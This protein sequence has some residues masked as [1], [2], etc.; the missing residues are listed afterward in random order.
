MSARVYASMQESPPLVIEIKSPQ[1][2]R[3]SPRVKY[4]GPNPHDN[5]EQEYA[6]KRPDPFYKVEIALPEDEKSYCH[7]RY[8]N[9]NEAFCQESACNSDP[10]DLISMDEPLLI[11]KHAC[12]EGYRNEKA[13]GII[14]EHL[15]RYI[16][17]PDG[18][19]ENKGCQA[20][21]LL[22]IQS[23]RCKKN[24]EKC[25]EGEKHGG[26]SSHALTRGTEYAVEKGYR[27]IVEGRLFEEGLLS[28]MGDQ[29]I[30]RDRHLPGDLRYARFIRR[31]QGMI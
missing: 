24:R 11:R 16:E 30:A 8:G 10:E 23:P 13:E 29:I 14:N 12:K 4:P 15:M 20:R 2:I 1:E 6:R 7:S 25:P 22:I 5:R 28:V 17:E 31:P 19:C 18:A 3:S 26:E 27:G 9:T 21:G